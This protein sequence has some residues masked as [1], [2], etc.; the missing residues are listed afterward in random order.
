MKARFIGTG[1]G[2]LHGVPGRN[3]TEVDWHNLTE[4][5]RQAVLDHPE[6]YQ[7]EQEAPA[8]RKSKQGEEAGS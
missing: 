1:E 4:E 3:L 2:F 7:L 5:Q 8:R 6:M